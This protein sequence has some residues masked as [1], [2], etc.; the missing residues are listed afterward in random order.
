[1]LNHGLQVIITGSSPCLLS[2]SQQVP[3]QQLNLKYKVVRRSRIDIMR[4]GSQTICLLCLP[5]LFSNLIYSFPPFPLEE[6]WCAS[7][8]SVL[9]LCS[10]T[11]QKMQLPLLRHDGLPC[12]SKQ[13]DEQQQLNLCHRRG[14]EKETALSL[15]VAVPSEGF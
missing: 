9:L 10:V 5:F 1:M 12:F 3:D 13:S 7:S 11:W 15:C 6:F 2:C 14:Q 8:L 4:C